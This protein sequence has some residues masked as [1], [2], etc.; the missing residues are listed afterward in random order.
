MTKMINDRFLFEG[1]NDHQ[2]DAAGTL[3][4]GRATLAAAFLSP[5][6]HTPQADS[7]IGEAFALGRRSLALGR[8]E[9][10]SN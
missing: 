3:A 2:L 6:A 10:Q 1:L 5:I 8:Q 4:L 9:E 7:M